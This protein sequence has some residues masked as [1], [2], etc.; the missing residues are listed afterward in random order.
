MLLLSGLVDFKILYST[1]D[2][3]LKNMI[4]N[5]ILYAIVL[6]NGI[7]LNM[8]ITP[9][10]DSQVRH[11]PFQLRSRKL[12]CI[13]RKPH[14][15]HKEITDFIRVHD[16]VV[17]F[18]RTPR[19]QVVFPASAEAMELLT[20][21][22]WMKTKAAENHIASYKYMN[23]KTLSKGFYTPCTPLRLMFSG[24]KYSPPRQSR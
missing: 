3:R 5:T 4:L 7:V 19:K 14:R 8:P 15:Q 16:V 17:V 11:L 1:Y 6:Y 13:K 12:A 2:P 24:I 23:C 18:I 9:V 10:H 21:F 22:L 20:K